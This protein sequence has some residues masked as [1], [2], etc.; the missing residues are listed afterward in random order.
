MKI[1]KSLDQPTTWLLAL[2]IVAATMAFAADEPAVEAPAKEA[3]E[4]NPYVPRDDL[5]TLE[6]FE[7]L[8]RMKGLP[9]SLQ[10]RPGFAEAM[11]ICA[12]RILAAQP[13]ET[14]RS[15]A[16]RAKMDGYQRGSIWNEE[17]T[18]RNEAQKKL[19]ELANQCLKDSDKQ[20]L[21]WAQFYL[22]EDK[23]LAAEKLDPEKLPE[24]L[25][26]V[27]KFVKEEKLDNRHVRLAST[28][29]KLI[30]KL[31][32]DDEADQAYK[33]FGGIFSASMDDELHRYGDRIAD[34]VPKRP[35]DLTGRPIPITGPL[36]DGGQFDV[37]NWKGNVVLVD[38][39]ATWCGPC[40]AL[41]PELQALHGR[42]QAR[43]FEIV[44]VNLDEDRGALKKF[45][46]ESP[47]P[48]PNIVDAESPAEARMAKKYGIV[49][50]PTTYLLDKEGKLVATNLH[51]EQLAAKIE[52]LLGVAK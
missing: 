9:K 39:W 47:L 46:D 24:V 44:G 25:D 50:I 28:T 40:R 21:H 10:G 49:G 6:L 36:Y 43:G 2:S 1:S 45:L 16:M 3:A 33:E 26:E 18:K 7:L 42:F 23:V 19:V 51:G 41:L 12:D 31:P 8:D 4:D 34:G 38:F 22:L 35:V 27:R 52:E 48:W 13:D 14:M 29:V 5:S 17:E 11:V 20:V 37:A 15:Y 30:N 32:G